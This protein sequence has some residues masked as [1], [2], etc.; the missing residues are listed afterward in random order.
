M[1]N[2]YKRI[3]LLDAGVAGGIYGIPNRDA[4]KLLDELA[5]YKDSAHN[6][7]DVYR[8]AEDK[9]ADLQAKLARYQEVLERIAYE[10]M[11]KQ[12][13]ELIDIAREALDV[14]EN[15]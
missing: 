3:K 2:K 10:A 8:Q 12:K 15:G 13:A 11:L 5:D 4:V 14:G 7:V 9:I 1:S 6:L